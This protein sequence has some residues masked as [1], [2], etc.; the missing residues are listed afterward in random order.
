MAAVR[1]LERVRELLAGEIQKRGAAVEVEDRS[2]GARIRVDTGQMN[3]LL[4]NLAQNAF[5][6]A[7]DA[8]RKPVLRLSAYRQGAAVC[9]ELEDNG[10]GIAAAEQGKIFDLFY[11]TR[12]GGTGLGLAIVERIARAH[13]GRVGVRST[14]G[15]GTAVIVELPAASPPEPSVGPAVEA[16]VG[17]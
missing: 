8:S 3:Q 9:L 10:V 13:G 11:S 6:A 14:E 1:P 17:A 5:S 16:A 12:K 15:V 4:I 7:E 2:G